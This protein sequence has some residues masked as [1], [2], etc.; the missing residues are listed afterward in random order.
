MQGIPTMHGVRLPL[1]TTFVALLLHEGSPRYRVLCGVVAR[2][3]HELC[4]QLVSPPPSCVR[5]LQARL[6]VAGAS[7]GEA[8]IRSG[9]E[10]P[11]SPRRSDLHASAGLARME[12]Q[13][14][15]VSIDCEGAGKGGLGWEG[16]NPRLGRRRRGGGRQDAHMIARIPWI[17]RATPGDRP[18]L[19]C[20]A[21]SLPTATQFQIAL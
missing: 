4:R 21:P 15:R 8:H 10:A 14:V 17:Q 9:V 2:N 5:V 1:P 16:G 7:F 20:I 6:F 19:V 3:R 12:L 18:A 13:P 11:S